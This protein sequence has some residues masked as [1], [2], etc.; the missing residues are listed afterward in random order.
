M[1]TIPSVPNCSSAPQTIN[2]T[3]PAVLAASTSASNFNGFG[4]SCNGGNNGSANVTVTGGTNP[5]NYNWSNGA[6][7]ANNSGLV[8]GNYNV[9]VTDANGCTV[10]S[11]ANI[12]EPAAL[13]A[14]TSTSNFNGYGVSCF[15][16]NNGSANVSV[17]G[18]VTAYS[19]N[20]S[21]GATTA[22]NT[23]L[24]A[25]NYNV[26]VTDANGCTAS[27][28]AAITQPAALV[29]ATSTS[30]FN[31]YGVSCF[32]GNNGSANVSVS[33][34]VTA[35]NYNWSN[36]ATTANNT[37]LVAGNYNVTVTDANGCT[38]SANATLTQPTALALTM[39]SNQV[40]YF[41]Y[42]PA[43]CTTLNSSVS[44]GVTAYNYNWTSGSTSSS[45]VVCPSVSTTYT[46]TV[47]DANGCTISGD[48]KVCVVNVV[49]YAGNSNV[50]KVEICH[51]PPGN[52]QN[53]QTIC[54]AASSVP[55]HL[56]HGDYLGSC[57]TVA[58]CSSSSSRSII[59]HD[60]DDAKL[61]GINYLVYPNPANDN[62]NIE[63]TFVE[64]GSG[65]IEITD[66]T[67]RVILTTPLISGMEGE[68]ISNNINVNEYK[69]GVYFIKLELNGQVLTQKVIKQ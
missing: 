13:V 57:G 1:A 55:S 53:P 30:N 63:F 7:T 28:N 21:N 18:G 41:G 42:T 23:G 31:G 48:V 45:A 61:D 20:W 56:A 26:T 64:S 40:V 69:A 51:I 3:Q 58:S 27:A 43:S 4:V 16:G 9:T 11:S 35:Y 10:S 49:C 39:P 60:Q 59:T 38:V 5:Y 46:L 14:A 25:G 52:N 67:G 34:G 47:T 8:A 68:T 32:G 22:N 36:G 2:I 37:G 50:A 62:L 15:G 54:V 33:G 65:K 66:V 12:T 17:G 24:V 29:A 6:T 19:F 44:G